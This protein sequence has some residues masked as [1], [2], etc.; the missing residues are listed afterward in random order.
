VESVIWTQLLA[1]N[2]VQRHKTSNKELDKL[3][4]V[5]RRDLAD[6]SLGGASADRRFA[7]AY[8]AALQSCKNGDCFALVIASSALDT[9]GFL[10]TW[11]SSRLA[12]LRTPIVITSTGAGGSGT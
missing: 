6:A 8:N 11:L 12:K 7:T 4:A 3:R 10:S 1:N 5:I 2:E 9:T